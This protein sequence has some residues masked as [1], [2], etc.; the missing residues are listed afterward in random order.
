MNL[1]RYSKMSIST[2]VA[3]GN[4][5]F[6]RGLCAILEEHKFE[7][8]S[9]IDNGALVLSAVEI[10]RPTLCVLS[11]N[12]PE[13]DGIELT[14][15]ILAKNENVH[16]LILADEVSQTVLHRFL[17]SGATGLLLKSADQ[18]EL[19]IAAK[20]VASNEKYVGKHFS[21]MMSD[22][23]AK[24]RKVSEIPK[25]ITKREREI[26]RLL[27]EGFTSSE[28]ALKLFISPRTV[29]KHRTNLLKKFKQKNTAAL[30]RFA[31]ESDSLTF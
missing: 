2:I 29:E 18:I 14:D 9:E 17:D 1:G 21:K 25:R 3:E 22:Q 30:V 8:K 20:S 4:E 19:S 10:I 24:L 16:V 12:L 13:I 7:I 11:F 5:I 6:R 28:I 15:R 31:S 27:M 23:Y 26:L